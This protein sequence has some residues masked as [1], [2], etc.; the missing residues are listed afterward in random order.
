MMLAEL[1]SRAGREK[2]RVRRGTDLGCVAHAL[3][4]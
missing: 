1:V 4:F 3:N 2:P